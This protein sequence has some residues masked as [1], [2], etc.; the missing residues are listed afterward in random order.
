M[1]IVFLSSVYNMKSDFHLK[2]RTKSIKQ[3]G[4]MLGCLLLRGCYNINVNFH[5]RLKTPLSVSCHKSLHDSPE[6][7]IRMSIKADVL[8]SIAG[9]KI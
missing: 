9:N 2:T 1:L 3:Q 4:S 5:Q 6:T 8:D 7:F